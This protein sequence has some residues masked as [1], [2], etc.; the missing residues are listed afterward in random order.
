[1]I[2]LLIALLAIV[3]LLWAINAYVPADPPIKMILCVIVVIVGIVVLVNAVGGGSA[4]HLMRLSP[5]LSGQ[6]QDRMYT[7]SEPTV[8]GHALADYS[9]RIQDGGVILTA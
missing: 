1:M 4:L 2:T 3:V 8:P 7:L 6:Q 5:E 9:Y